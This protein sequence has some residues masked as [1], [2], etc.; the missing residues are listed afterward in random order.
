[1]NTPW[2]DNTTGE[3]WGGGKGVG[4]GVNAGGGKGDISNTFDSKDKFFFKN[5][6]LKIQKKKGLFVHIS[7]LSCK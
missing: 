7:L 6:S 2:T 1:M 3:G 5:E 4:E